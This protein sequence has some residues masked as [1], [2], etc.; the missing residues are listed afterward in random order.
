M[1]MPA[2]L[3]GILERVG[4]WALQLFLGSFADGILRAQKE[5]ADREKDA[6]KTQLESQESGKN[7]EM[8]IKDLQEKVEADYKEKLKERPNDRLGINTYNES[9]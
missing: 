7:L 6:L 8:E 1:P 9:N 3:I 4:M 2:F 5:K